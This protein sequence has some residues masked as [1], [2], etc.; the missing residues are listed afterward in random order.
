M[1]GTEEPIVQADA[2]GR[3]GPDG[4]WLLKDVSFKIHSGDH[5][6]IQGPT[7]AGKTLLLRALALLDTPDAGVIRWRGEP[8]A[9]HKVPSY[10]RT[11]AYLPQRPALIEGS[12]EANLRL[13]FALRIH[14]ERAFERGRALELLQLL[15]C[16]ESFLKRSCADLS[17]G[18]SQILALVRLLQLDPAV[19]LLDEPTASLDPEATR[20][21]REMVV[22]WAESGNGERAYVWVSHDQELAQQVSNRQLRLQGGVLRVEA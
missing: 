9:D 13:P 1:L 18:E 11:V 20:S 16:D 4:A 22:S 7:G 10:R 21:A 12:V 17:G 5:M 19:L 8:V 15:G 3:R 6:A 2:I 14:Q